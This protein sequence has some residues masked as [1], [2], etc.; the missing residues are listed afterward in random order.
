MIN[1]VYADQL[2]QFPRLQDA[3]FKDRAAQFKDRLGWQV[4]VDENGWE[5]DEY[6]HFESSLHDLARS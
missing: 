1:Y 4:L 5:R 3:M 6:R 2:A